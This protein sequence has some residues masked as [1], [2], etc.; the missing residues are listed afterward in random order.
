MYDIRTFQTASNLTYD[1]I[2]LKGIN[3]LLHC[4]LHLINC[5]NIIIIIIIINT[6]KFY[7]P[8]I[9]TFRPSGLSA[10]VRSVNDEGLLIFRYGTDRESTAA[11]STALV[12]QC[13]SACN[14]TEQHWC[15]SASL[16]VTADTHT[17]TLTHRSHTTR[18]SCSNT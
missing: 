2:I 6:N 11:E 10:L 15:D 1:I 12:W 16:P 14:S 18:Q 4:V 9:Q 13:K 7:S 17:R 3:M 8:F 5:R